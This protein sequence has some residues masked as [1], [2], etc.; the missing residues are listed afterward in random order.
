M[1]TILP[2]AT[3]GARQFA[4][5]LTAQLPGLR[6]DVTRLNLGA[7]QTLK[8]KRDRLL[9]MLAELRQRRDLKK[10]Q[11]GGGG[12]G[13]AAA[14]GGGAIGAGVGALVG[15]PIGALIGGGIGAG[16]GGAVDITTG[17]S[18]GAGT[19][20]VQA[21]QFGLQAFDL[22]GDLVDNPLETGGFPA[23]GPVEA[24]PGGSGRLAVP[25]LGP[26]AT[27][28]AVFRSPGPLLGQF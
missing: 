7:A 27:P 5:Q 17:G 23:L 10:A 4:G 2:P 22:F 19:A 8:D 24:F 16:V 11:R 21:A 9:A 18:G 13:G 1:A 28:G 3:A 12:T 6:R 25:T 14:L 26:A 15:G 20:G